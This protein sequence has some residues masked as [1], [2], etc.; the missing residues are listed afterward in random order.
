L[1]KDTGSPPFIVDGNI[2]IGGESGP[3]KG[4]GQ[5]VCRGKRAGLKG[6]QGPQ[7]RVEAAC[8]AC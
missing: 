8:T 6:E 3:V 4:A 1:V 2:N 7:G 5:G